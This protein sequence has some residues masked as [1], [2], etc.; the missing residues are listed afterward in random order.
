MELSEL[1]SPAAADGFVRSQP[2]AQFSQSWAWGELERAEGASV[3][4]L[5]VRRDGRLVASAQLVSRRL[6]LGMSYLYCPRGPVLDHTLDRDSRQAALAVV[7]S[8]AR[9]IAASTS[10]LELAV[11]LEPPLPPSAAGSLRSL[12][13]EPTAAVQP[14]RTAMLDL[15]LGPDRLLAGM[16]PKARYNIGLA[17]R[18]GIVVK[19]VDDAMSGVDEL[20]R[21]MRQT[22]AR[23]GFVP[24][25]EAHYRNFLRHLHGQ[26]EAPTAELWLAAVQGEPPLAAALTVR[27]GDTVTY[28]HG[29]SDQAF[30]HLMAPHL[31]QWRIIE[32]AAAAGYRYYDLWGIAPAGQ[33]N[34]PWAG[35]TRF[36][37]GFGGEAV[38][39][40][41][42]WDYAQQPGWYHLYQLYRRLRGK[43]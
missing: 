12:G 3:W 31:V 18:H 4:R 40:V 22:A 9:R 5:G 29:A 19:R 10:R 33:T 36:K 28:V 42:T 34:H 24:H 6:P 37:E 38:D 41:G 2:H 35:F 39:Y 11:R 7:L 16:H 14:S 20:C 13:L 30:R 15:A 25:P 43:A 23:Q 26:A 21:L 1:H 17:A 27:W 8:G 32:D